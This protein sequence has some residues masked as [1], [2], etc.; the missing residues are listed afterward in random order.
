MTN[1]YFLAAP[2]AATTTAVRALDDLMARIGVDG[3]TA[4]YGHPGLLAAVDQHAADVRQT[5]RRAGRRLDAATL[6]G[7]AASIVAG[8]GRMGRALPR[9]GQ[10]DSARL[11]WPHAEWHL[12]RLVAVCALAD[13]RGLLS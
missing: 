1:E 3:L 7:Y 4:A 2:T 6:A 8:A 5:L 11:H 9:P 10:A 13:D 12:V